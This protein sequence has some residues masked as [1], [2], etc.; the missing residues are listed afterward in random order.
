MILKGSQRGEGTDLAT[1]LMNTYD[2]E[3][4]EIGEVHGAVAEDLHGAFA[5]FEAVSLGTKAREY[6]Y[7]LSI[8]PPSKMSREQ[9]AD[10]I[11]EIEKG[12][13]LTGQPRAVVFHVKDGRE[14]C[15][16]V[17]SRINVETMRAIH[18]SHDHS[19]LMDMACKLARK[20]GFELPDGLKKWEAKQ[21][22]EKDYLE[23]TRAENAQAEETGITPEMRAAQITEA[24]NQSDTAEAFRAALEQQGYIVAKSDRRDFVVVDEFGNVHS[25]SR[26]IKGHKPKDKKAKLAGLSAVHLPSVEQAK[27]L[28]LQIAQARL[29]AQRK[30]EETS[31]A[32]AKA[33]AELRA[34]KDKRQRKEQESAIRQAARRLK[35]QIAEQE[36]LTR[37]QE[38]RLLLHVAQLAESKGFLFRIRSTVADLIGRVPGLRS[39]LG[40]LQNLTH[41]DPKE[42]HRLED[43]ALS[44]RHARERQSIERRKGKLALVEKREQQSRAKALRLEQRLEG[45]IR[46]TAEQSA[47]ISKETLAQ[48]E[49]KAMQDFYDAARDQGLWQQRVFEE[50]E[51]RQTFND[52][53]G[54]D[55]TP[56]NSGDGDSH[57]PD[58][59]DDPDDDGDDDD[60]KMRRRRGKGYGYRRD[61]D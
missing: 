27:E 56:P 15:H 8:S 30:H 41:L 42:R 49:H 48:A 18:M 43:E 60:P 10:T 54:I 46:L 13:G 20:Y 53:A 6:L 29:D 28:A 36:L 57:T 17:W 32:M 45:K 21:R 37:Q 59:H 5:E 9:Y 23:A 2:N 33:Q 11:R 14:H 38:E 1:H 34:L 26:H 51:L 16:V 4:I 31:E 3:F 52:A 24:Y 40:P 7:S 12:L 47:H 22:F 44:R 50:G 25:L 61:S 19:R 55:A 39:V 35:V 58:P